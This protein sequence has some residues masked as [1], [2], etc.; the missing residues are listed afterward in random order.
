MII[1]N[2]IKKL[3]L[4]LLSVSLLIM[5]AIFIYSLINLDGALLKL[6]SLIAIFFFLYY[7]IR[8]ILYIRK[9]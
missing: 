9:Q 5:I 8:G 4:L 6:V 7:F 3:V 1:S 2:K